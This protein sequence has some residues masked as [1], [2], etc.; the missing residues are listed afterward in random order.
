M[1]QKV[2]PISMRLGSMRD[3]NSRWYATKS[4]FSEN[5][6]QD[7]KIRKLIEK[8]MTMASISHI[9]IERATK[10]VRVK[11][12]S[13]RPGMIIGRKGVQIE[14]LRE[15]LQD[16]TGNEN[17][18][19][20]DIKE[21]PNPALDA[22][23]IADSVAFQLVKRVAFRRAM[24]KTLQSVKDAGGEGVKI[25]CSGRL[26]G[27]EIARTE[28]YKWGKV[29]LQTIRADIDY[30]LSVAKTAYGTIGVKIWL[31]KGEKMRRE[32]SLE[33]MEEKR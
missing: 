16:I 24:K 29:P 7:A 26:G 1:G 25:Q 9:D 17:K 8:E 21:V 23:I 18:L 28:G 27:A 10:R 30:A 12:Y 2:H 31:Y 19:Y 14:K 3:W 15:L 20:I 11:I 6:L 32:V 5:V 13:G 33:K 22:K 4:E